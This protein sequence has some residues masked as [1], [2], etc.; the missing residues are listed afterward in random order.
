[1]NESG[2]SYKPPHPPAHQHQ[3]H[4]N[5]G[6]FVD[7][8][9]DRSGERMP[10]V[11]HPSTMS[12]DLRPSQL[13][14]KPMDRR[15]NLSQNNIARPP[16]P[17]NSVERSNA[18]YAG[19]SSSIAQM[20]QSSQVMGHSWNDP[21]DFQTLDLSNY[22]APHPASPLSKHLNKLLPPNESIINFFNTLFQ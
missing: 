16:P 19:P 12:Q 1:M 7:N 3:Q 21:Y 11:G 10:P 5:N 4:A 20:A 18:S 22:P 17:Q 13:P 8:A 6:S 2:V 9:R 14:N 15:S